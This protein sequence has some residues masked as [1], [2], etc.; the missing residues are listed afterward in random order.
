MSEKRVTRS[1]TRK[2]LIKRGTESDSKPTY[3]FSRKRPF[4]PFI[5][6]SIVVSFYIYRNVKIYKKTNYL[7]FFYFCKYQ[8]TQY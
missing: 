3:N 6:D 4:V 7:V 2:A 1:M 8:L 5:P